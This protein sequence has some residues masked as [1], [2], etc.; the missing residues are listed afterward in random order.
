M[1]EGIV[2]CAQKV[3]SA[4]THAISETHLE[5]ATRYSH[6]KYHHTRHSRERCRRALIT[7]IRRERLTGT[8]TSSTPERRDERASIW[9]LDGLKVERA[10]S[11]GES[12]AV[13]VK[14]RRR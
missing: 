1:Q 10:M 5:D 11:M 2:L 4:S 8:Q 3:Q 14:A 12:R 13:P 6:E 7:S 9:G